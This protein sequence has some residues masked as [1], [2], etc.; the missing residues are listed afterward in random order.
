MK[1]SNTRI[2][3]MSEILFFHNETEIA[4]YSINLPGNCSDE[5]RTRHCGCVEQIRKINI[6]KIVNDSFDELT[7][8]LESNN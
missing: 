1:M 5:Y 4:P 8:K 6:N 2:I 7:I 3:K